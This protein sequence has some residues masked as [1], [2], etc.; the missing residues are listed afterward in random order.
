M[1]NKG[2]KLNPVNIGR[3]VYEAMIKYADGKGMKYHKVVE[4]AI[5]DYIADKSASKP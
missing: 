4:F 1:K 2:R 3:E 5:R